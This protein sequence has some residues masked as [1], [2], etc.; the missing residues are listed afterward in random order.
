MDTLDFVD[1]EDLIARSGH[2]D[3]Q[4]ERVDD[5]RSTYID[6]GG[7]VGQSGMI[8]T[9]SDFDGQ[10]GDERSTLK[11]TRLYSGVVGSDALREVGY[12]ND[13]KL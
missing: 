7:I 10:K 4:S 8:S 1:D 6:R 9:Q 11:F 3:G 13:N 5:S 12:T 2:D